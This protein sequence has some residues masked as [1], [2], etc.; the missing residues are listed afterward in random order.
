MNYTCILSVF[1]C[2]YI[3]QILYSYLIHQYYTNP[4]FCNGLQIMNENQ[5]KEELKGKET[6]FAVE[7]LLGLP[8]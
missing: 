7:E 4:P 3:T 6:E 8:R 1:S 2:I 5:A